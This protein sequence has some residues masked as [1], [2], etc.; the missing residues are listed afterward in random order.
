MS[1]NNTPRRPG[2][3]KIA[4][5]RHTQSCM[6]ISG[7]TPGRDHEKMIFRCRVMAVVYLLT[8]MAG[9]IAIFR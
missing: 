6:Q 1:A 8:I 9:I 5:Y 4:R 2:Q 3:A 7:C